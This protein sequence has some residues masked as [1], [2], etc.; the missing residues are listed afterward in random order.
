MLIDSTAATSSARRRLTAGLAASALLVG[1]APAAVAM[2]REDA[3]HGAAGI[4]DSYYPHDGNGGIDVS[5]YDVHDR[6]DFARGRLSGWTDVTLTATQ[7]L[8][9]F[10]LDLLLPVQKVSVDGAEVPFE[11]AGGGHE[12][13]IDAAVT[14]GQEYVVRV[15]YAGRPGEL[16][17]NGE[18]NWLADRREVVTMN[19]PHMAPWWFPANDHP[20]DKAALDIHVTVPKGKQVVANGERV[21]RTVRDGLATTHWRATEP[22]A[23]YLAF[24]AAGSFVVDRG[25]DAA[26]RPWVVAVSE[27]ADNRA[28]MLRMMKRHDDVVAWLEEHVG[29]YPFS[30]TGG[31]YTVLPAGF[32]LE[33]QTR[34]TYSQWADLPTV[35]HEA[36][37][38]WF[39]DDVAVENWRD[40]WLNEGF[41][42]FF[43][44][45]WT[46][47]HGGETADGW[48]RSAYRSTPADAGFWRQH[49][50]DPGAGMHELFSGA[51]YYRGAMTVQALRNRVGEDDFWTIVRTWVAEQGGGNGSSEEFE[52]LAEQVSGEDLDGFFT[53]WLRT[54]ERPART[55][56]NGLD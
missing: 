40:I 9:G 26:G 12:L 18:A 39:G 4:G 55:A 43:E 2:A 38:Q 16:R 22:M 45:Y 37:H 23:P 24:F 11:K 1:L 33:N 7:T 30:T 31:V 17:Y 44:K 8:S 49:I 10:N 20:R 14:A 48:L 25:T 42:T 36:A 35:I 56:A 15:R 28:R 34:P 13:V 51:V 6:Y 29:D 46:E 5:H 53:A 52:T 54:G 19:Q 27:R 41:A 32:A 21:G 3:P 50:A 47:T